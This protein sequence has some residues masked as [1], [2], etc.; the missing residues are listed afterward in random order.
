MK[1]GS[2]WKNARLNYFSA[3]VLTALCGIAMYVEHIDFFEIMPLRYSGYKSLFENVFIILSAFDAG[4]AT[5][6]MNYLIKRMKKGDEEV[7]LS[8]MG[9]VE[10]CYRNAV[11]V[12]LLLGLATA[13]A[14]PLLTMGEGTWECMMCFLIYL[15]GELGQYIFGPRALYLACA[16]KSRTVSLFVQG[17]KIIMYMVVMMVLKETESY[18]LY[19][20]LC[21]SIMLLSYF[22]LHLKAGRDYPVLRKVSRSSSRDNGEIGRNHLGMTLHRMSFVFFRSFEPV[23]VSILFGSAAAGVY[24]NYLL[25][26]YCFL[27]PFWI[28]QT[29]VGPSVA[30]RCINGEPEDNLLLYRKMSALNFLSSLLASFLFLLFITPY[31]SF[32][33]GN[34]YHMGDSWNCIFAFIV[35]LSSF[36]TTAIVFRNTEGEYS[37]D[38]RKA[39]VEMVSVLVLAPLLSRFIGLVGIPVAFIITYIAVVI[40]REKKTVVSSPLLCG[41]WDD[42]AKDTF[43]MAMGLIMI[44]AVWYV[45]QL[46]PLGYASLAVALLSAVFF[47]LWFLA[48][49]K[50]ACAVFSKGAK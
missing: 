22:L 29:T 8:A 46:L 26:V 5:Y 38:W 9:V 35:F 47:L 15:L 17:G 12:I 1:N 18:L 6:L 11:L 10:R 25:F 27:S 14:M 28:F 2:I 41:G 39:V 32:S 37:V 23:L 16:E 48:D 30:A 42:V 49:R 13:M 43:L 24:S 20:T 40:W 36:R 19:V 50:T 4:V 44:V 7:I 3:A 34:E 33:Y 21:S 45:T 31:I